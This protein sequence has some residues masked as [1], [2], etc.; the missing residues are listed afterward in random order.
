M[1]FIELNDLYQKKLI[2]EIKRREF[3]N[4]HNFFFF[5]HFF[6]LFLLITK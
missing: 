3:I 6:D 2:N 1:S 5:F 4:F